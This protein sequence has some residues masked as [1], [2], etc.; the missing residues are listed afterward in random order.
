MIFGHDATLQ[1]GYLNQASG[2]NSL[3]QLYS[4]FGVGIGV[5]RVTIDEEKEIGF[6]L[7]SL[8]STVRY[9]GL[10]NNFLKGSS[11][12]ILVLKVEDLTYAEGL[13]ELARHQSQDPVMI[14]AIG[15]L[16]QSSESVASISSILGNQ[17]QIKSADSVGETLSLLARALNKSGK[18]PIKFPFIVALNE[19]SCPEFEPQ[20][21]R[22]SLPLS[23][24]DEVKVILN[25]AN[26]LNVL[27]MANEIQVNLSEGRTFIE[28]RSGDIRFTPAFCYICKKSCRKEASICI[29]GLDSGWSSEG[30]GK[31][32][33]LTMAKINAFASQNLPKHVKKQLLRASNCPMFKLSSEIEPEVLSEL[34]EEL[35]LV[36]GNKVPTLLDAAKKRVEDGRLPSSAYDI[37]KSSLQKVETLKEI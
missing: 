16:V 22:Y 31:R 2:T 35:N 25:F 37:L 8:P 13:L 9:Q 14:V 24:D 34:K 15:S 17:L 29:V 11:A 27:V 18:E 30:V 26:E 33:L 12:T 6:Q 7:W 23:T 5:S 32:A 3:Y 4:T 36:Q 28:P 1:A 10:T 19:E 21:G 20:Q